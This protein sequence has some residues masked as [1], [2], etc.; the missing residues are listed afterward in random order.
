MDPL[1]AL[2]LSCNVLDLLSRGIKTTVLIKEIYSSPE[3]LRKRHES[4]V[5]ESDTLATIAEAL[6]QAKD[7]IADSPVD[8]RMHEV[9]KN[10][11]AACLAVEDVIDKCRP[12]KQNSFFSAV[13]ASFR[14]LLHKSDIDE[15][16]AQLKKGY[17]Q[18]SALV[19]E[20][21]RYCPPPSPLPYARGAS[22]DGGK[23]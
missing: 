10:C 8:E 20:R 13:G 16:E 6:Q 15:L 4:L 1:S 2:S 9:A 18:L 11:S 14:I 12:K 7:D 21:T 23:Q 3:G 22:S 19:S 17:D 5:K